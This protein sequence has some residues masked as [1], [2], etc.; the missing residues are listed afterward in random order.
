MVKGNGNLLRR[1]VGVAVSVARRA[2]SINVFQA[3]NNFL[4]IN[5]MI[6]PCSIY[7]N[8][9]IGRE[10]GAVESDEEGIQIMIELGKNMAWLIKTIS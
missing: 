10:I 4:F 7:W 2:G 1:K 3:I 9:G 5:G 8:F 6:V